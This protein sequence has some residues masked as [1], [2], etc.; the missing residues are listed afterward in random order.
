MS[1]D[2]FLSLPFGWGICLYTDDGEIVQNFRRARSSRISK[3]QSQENYI[4]LMDDFVTMLTKC[5]EYL[6][7]DKSRSCIFV[8]SE[9]EKITI[10]D[11]LLDIITTD[12]NVISYELHHAATR[13]LFNLFEDSSLIST[14]GN[15]DSNIMEIPDASRNEWREFPRLI[16]LEHVLKENIAIYVP[17]FYRFIDIWQQ[18]VKP[19][20]SN[21]QELLN[22]LEQHI[23]NIKYLY[24]MAYY[25][26]IKES[27]DD[28]TSKLIFTPPIFTFTEIKAFRNHYLGKLY[29]FK[30]YEAITECMRIRS[31]RIKDFTQDESICGVQLRYERFIEKEWI[32]NEWIVKFTIINNEKDASLLEPSLFKK[33]IL[34]E[35]NPKGLREAIKFSDME[36][37]NKTP[38]VP[39]LAIVYLD[40]F[41]DRT[42]Y[43]K[44][45]FNMMDLKKFTKY[46][47]YNR[48][49]DFNLDKVLTTFTEMDERNN[50]N[51]SVFV[52]LLKDPNAWGSGSLIEE[53]QFSTALSLECMSPSQKEISEVLLKKKASN[54]LGPPG[55]GKTYFF[56]LFTTWYL[57]TFTD[58]NKRYVI[59]VTAFTKDA[60]ANLLERISF[61][62]NYYKYY[63]KFT[64]FSMIKNVKRDGIEVC[65]EDL[66]KKIAEC[67]NDS[68][69]KVLNLLVSDAILAIEC[70]NPKT[71][72]LIVAGDHMQLGPIIKN[73][74]PTF[75]SDHPLIFGSI[76]QCLMRREDRSIIHVENLKEQKYDFGPLTTQLKENWRMNE[77]L[78]GFFQ[79]IYGRNYISRNPNLKLALDDQKLSQLEDL[80]IRRILSPESA[81]TLVKVIINELENYDISEQTKIEADVVEKI[82]S[83]YF[84]SL[85]AEEN[86][87]LFIITP[88]HRQ[89]L[90]IK[91]RLKKS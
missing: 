14:A 21:D 4:S 16:I 83:S 35:D 80:R 75:H 55:S 26:L 54:H 22:S 11:A 15:K 9:R 37:R 69:M 32:D 70:L 46:R 40:K 91:S 84:E 10:Q 73:S 2:T 13:C 67:T 19:T 34:V 6:S 33:F 76:Q 43:L 72:K 86:Q 7:Q 81:I 24:F 28:I 51:K 61:T 57:S 45:N 49:F 53:R 66:S 1:L 62:R 90:E 29:F 48:Y 59:G 63:D 38:S 44:G 74:Y 31:S 87:K 71:G 5:F 89:R 8:Y 50:D 52:D 25:K 68:I 79:K 39:S 60:I 17:G 47:L 27:T 42:I 65:E 23:M 56:A 88:Y 3:N 64:I 12:G 20:L 30:Q 78:N 77:E 36:Y 58:T 41:E 18:L 85:K 82:I